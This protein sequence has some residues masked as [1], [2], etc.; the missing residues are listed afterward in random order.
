MSALSLFS[1][2]EGLIRPA[3][4]RQHGI[5]LRPATAPDVGFLRELYHQLRAAELAPLSWPEPQK[6]A[7]TDSQFDL[8]H[9]H[10]LSHFPNAEFLL[11][12]WRAVPIGRFYLLRQAPE[13]HLIDISLM[14]QWRNRGVGSALIRAAQALARIEKA[15]LNLH[16]DRRNDSAQRLYERLGFIAT[17]NDGLYTG[18]RWSAACHA[19]EIQPN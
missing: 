1:V 11:I 3:E 13:F 5:T 14:P 7:F 2:G 10:Y 9:R 8:Q 17:E 18:M 19:E 15:G 12:E 4:L 6:R 16:V